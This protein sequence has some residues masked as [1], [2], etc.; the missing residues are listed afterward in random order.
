MKNPAVLVTLIASIALVISASIMS[1]AITTFG[2]SLER[3]ATSK[4]PNEIRIPSN[5][6]IDFA[7]GNRPIRIDLEE[8]QK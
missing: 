2:R 1:S 8:T 3:A 6:T 7:G 4:R 5:F